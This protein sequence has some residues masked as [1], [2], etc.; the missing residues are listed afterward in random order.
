MLFYLLLIGM[1]LYFGTGLIVNIMY[2]AEK[3]IKYF[4]DKD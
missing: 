2:I 3:L 4:N 1:F